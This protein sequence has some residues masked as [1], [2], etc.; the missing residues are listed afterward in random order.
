MSTSAASF[1]LYQGDCFDLL[2]AIP[3]QSVDFICTDMPYGITRAKW[4]CKINL[5]ALWPELKR[6]IKPKGAIALFGSGKFAY[7]L[8]ASNFDDFRYRY[9]WYKQSFTPT[10]FLNANRRP[11]VCSEDILIFCTGQPKYN[12]Q[13]RC[14]TGGGRRYTRRTPFRSQLYTANIPRVATESKDGLRFPIDVL[15]FKAIPTTK[16]RRH[17]TQKPQ[18]LLEFLIKTYTD[19]GETVL[20]PFMGSGSCGVACL[21]TGRRFIGMEKEPHFFISAKEWLA[22]EQTR[23]DNEEGSDDVRED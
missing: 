10:G 23:L 7:K 21:S 14:P 8:A 11:M 13:R 3:D 5:S 22:A 18:D 2:R 1:Q 6:V 20:D 16:Q 12:P 17:N 19:S 15:T 4:D 9:T